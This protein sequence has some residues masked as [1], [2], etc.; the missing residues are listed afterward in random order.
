[1]PER[2]GILAGLFFLDLLIKTGKSPSEILDY[3]YNKVGPHH[4]QRIDVNFP[5]SKRQAIINHIR[6]NFPQSIDGVKVVNSDTTDDDGRPV[7]A[8]LLDA[9][10]GVVVARSGEPRVLKEELQALDREM[11]RL[12]READLVDFSDPRTLSRILA[13]ASDSLE[14][15]LAG[16]SR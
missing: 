11:G 14:A 5:D 2:D 10:R 7:D 15:L 1:M 13:Q 9:I 8:G 3:L 12:L 4:Y 6:N 16:G